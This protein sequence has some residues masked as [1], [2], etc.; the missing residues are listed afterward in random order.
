MWLL[1]KAVAVLA[2]GINKRGLTKETR[3]RMDEGISTFNRG[4]FDYLILSGSQSNGEYTE[5]E[6]M[7]IYAVDRGIPAGKILIENRSKDTL[8]NAYFIKK[9]MVENKISSVCVITSSYHSI[10]T[11]Y[12]FSET[13]RGFDVSFKFVKIAGDIKR[14]MQLLKL[15]KKFLNGKKGTKRALLLSSTFM[16]LRSMNVLVSKI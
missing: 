16:Q 3:A 10:R 2:G 14:E 15:T 9:L 4:E 13:M 8:G 11:K 7:K 1:K 6:L 12:I 5:S